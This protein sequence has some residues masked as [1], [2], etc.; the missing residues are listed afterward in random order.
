MLAQCWE[1][2]VDV[3]RDPKRLLLFCCFLFNKA[4]P[5]APSRTLDLLIFPTSKHNRISLQAPEPLHY[6]SLLFPPAPALSPSRAWSL[7]FTRL[8]QHLCSPSSCHITLHTHNIFFPCQPLHHQCQPTTP[9]Y[10]SNYSHAIE[11]WKRLQGLL[12]LALH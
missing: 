3:P 10:S 9:L 4:K 12:P 2:R 5:G 6:H 1:Q 7:Y 8:L 11:S